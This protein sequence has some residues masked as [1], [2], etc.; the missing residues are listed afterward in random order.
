MKTTTYFE[1]ESELVEELAKHID[2]LYKPRNGVVAIGKEESAGLGIFD[3]AI[4]SVNKKMFSKRA[5]SKL[6]TPITSESMISVLLHLRA[7]KP[8]TIKY[9]QR[10]TGINKKHLRT[11]VLKYLVKYKYISRSNHENYLK[12]PYY[13]NFVK[14]CIAIEAKLKKWNDALIQA[15]RYKAFANKTYV[16]LSS[17]FTGPAL[18]NINKF[19]AMNVG[20][21]EVTKDGGI[22]IILKPKNEK[23]KS[24][25]AIQLCNEIIV[26]NYYRMFLSENSFKAFSQASK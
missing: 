16:A 2:K 17:K 23:P 15:Y 22:R 11:K 5:A 4:F 26:K 6:G 3:Y 10:H 14:Y 18:R 8:R 21:I 13:G 12:N 1:K 19:K 24:R 20:L 7:D 25:I 9:L